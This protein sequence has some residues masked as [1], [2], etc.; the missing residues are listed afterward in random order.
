MGDITKLRSRHD[1]LTSECNAIR[2]KLAQ[3]AERIKGFTPTS[4]LDANRDEDA[5]EIAQLE[6]DLANVEAETDVANHDRRTYG[7]MI[8]R[9]RHQETTYRRDLGQIDFQQ[10]AKQS[11]A[12]QLYLMLKDATDVRDAARAELAR[13]D[14][15]LSEE[16]AQ[17]NAR[18]QEKQQRLA[19][20]REAATEHAARVSE[21][22]RQLETERLEAEKRREQMVVVGSLDSE[23]EQIQRLQRVFES[24]AEVI[25]VS[26][27]EG[28]VEKFK[29]QEETYALLANLHRESRKKIEV[30][31]RERDEKRKALVQL[32][33]NSQASVEPPPPPMPRSMS[34]ALGGA[35]GG[36]ANEEEERQRQQREARMKAS[37]AKRMTGV[38]IQAQHAINQLSSMLRSAKAMVGGERSAIAQK[39]DVSIGLRI[40]RP[41]PLA[42]PQ[43]VLKA[44]DLGADATSA[45]ASSASLIELLPPSPAKG[46]ASGRLKTASSG[47]PG[48]FSPPK[49]PEGRSAGELAAAAFGPASGASSRR[50][51]SPSKTQSLVD[52][53]LL[54][55][56]RELLQLLTAL[57]EKASTS[58]PLLSSPRPSARKQPSKGLTPP[59]SQQSA[60]AE[61]SADEA[62]SDGQ[63]AA[64]PMAVGA[65]VDAGD[66][67]G[68]QPEPNTSAAAEEERADEDEELPGVDKDGIE[69]E[70]ALAPLL[71]EAGAAAEFRL[72]ERELGVKEEEEEEE[73]GEEEEEEIGEAEAILDRD[74]LKLESRKIVQKRNSAKGRRS[75]KSKLV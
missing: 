30:L 52:T 22:L 65:G 4:E 17:S 40:I 31:S 34:G 50:S 64:S 20:R 35:M 59:P 13:E 69:S 45:I 74:A 21:K 38:L 16:N 56:M 27:A 62:M 41:P 33:Y 32:R 58:A 36:L 55:T 9:L 14:E 51:T 29:A 3:L 70:V 60:A 28:I 42:A 37:R 23:R 68:V 7:L 49:S 18:L 72:G 2:N 75:R 71:M 26:E 11:D 61:A 6:S 48:Q 67:G 53:E 15:A 25:G 43:A 73:M 54:T 46:K 10:T 19:A 39:R 44:G 12:K 8:E 66:E 1:D 63:R 5:A 47:G 24:I 57:I